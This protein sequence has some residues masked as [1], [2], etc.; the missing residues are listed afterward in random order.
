M[1][2]TSRKLLSIIIFVILLSLSVSGQ[3]MFR[4]ILD[5][6]GDGKTDYVVTR[7]ENNLLVWYVWQ[8]TAG[9]KVFQ[10]GLAASDT[11]VAGD[12]DGDGKTDF[13]IHRFTFSFNTQNTY[14]IHQSSTNSVLLK[15][16]NA[17][18]SGDL[19]LPQD[20]DG[21]GKTDAAIFYSEAG[22]NGSVSIRSS[23]T[24]TFIGSGIL[25]SYQPVRIGD[26]DGDGKANM[27]SV[28]S[29]ST[30]RLVNIQTGFTRIIGFGLFGD[31][32]IPADFNGDGVGD[33][34]VWRNSDGNWYWLRSS[35]NVFEISH[36]GQN[37]DIPVPGD[38]D[39]DGKTDLAVWR[40]TSPQSQY[41]VNG[42]QTGLRVFSF[43]LPSDKVIRY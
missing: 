7:N 1:K 12:Y 29:A 33:L 26:T 11:P 8:S 30:V 13:A 4:K 27:V 3:N 41:W 24:D 34:A 5:F 23:L 19:P 42:S 14:F 36:F 18:S 10:W 32:Y 15:Q 21:D 17:N 31:R 22:L 35:D 2:K 39:G 9:F 37:G 40:P 43:G 28:N 38:Y 6:D 20:Y 25:A 16:F